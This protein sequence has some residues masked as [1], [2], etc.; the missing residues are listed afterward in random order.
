MKLIA[1]TAPEKPCTEQAVRVRFRPG[2]GR[3]KTVATVRTCAEAVALI[4][5][6]GD[7]WLETVHAVLNGNCVT[8]TPSL[9]D[10]VA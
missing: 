5:G 7:W 2:R 6:P 10:E 8:R 3:W 9:F 1:L 4:D